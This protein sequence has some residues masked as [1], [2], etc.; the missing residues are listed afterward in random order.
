MLAPNTMLQG[1]YLVL[2]QVGKGG[3]GAVYQ[4]TDTR[5]DCTVALKEMLLTDSA[6][7]K[8]FEREAQ[9]LAR[10]RHPTLPRVSDHFL[11]GD[12]QFLVMEFIP[13]DDLAELLAR[14]GGQFPAED[15]LGWGLRWADQLLDAL[16]YLH[17]QTVPVIH[18]DIKPQNL[19]LTPRGDIILLDFGLARNISALVSTMTARHS[20]T[21]GGFTL[22]YAPLEQI[23]GS[24]PDPRSDLYALAATLYHIL[25]GVRPP[26]A[27]TRAAALLNKTDDPLRPAHTLNAQI[28]TGVAD[29]LHAALSL[30]LDERPE[31]AAAMRAALQMVDGARS[32]RRLPTLTKNQHTHTA[33]TSTITRRFHD[34]HITDPLLNAAVVAPATSRTSL[35]DLLPDHDQGQSQP[36]IAPLAPPGMLLRTIPTG[37]QLRSLAFS[38]DG[39]LLAAGGEDNTIGLWQSRTGDL[40]RTLEGHSSSIRSVTFSPDGYLLAAGGEDKTVRLWHV[41][42]GQLIYTQSMFNSHAECLAFTPDGGLLASGGWGEAIDLWRVTE[43]YLHKV[44]SLPTG[45]VHSIVFSPD[46]QILAAGCYD[47]TVRLWNVSQR[48]LVRTLEGYPNF[49]HSVAFSPDGQRLAAGGGSPTILVWRVQDGRLLDTLEGH[50]NF[51][52]S[53][54]FNH[55][56]QILA[57]GSEDK[58]V[59]LWRVRDGSLLHVLYEHTSGVMTVVFGPDGQMLA[60][61]S[62]DTKLRLWQVA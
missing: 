6:M 20:T 5:L 51:V 22:N 36:E 16:D 50:T 43:G 53:V 14:N 2:R 12:G 8:A 13:G 24:D 41:E 25:T 37:S 62:R 31:S 3:M 45:F 18:Q 35:L 59:R 9:L 11:E 7:R 29:V 54:A 32:R 58:T 4:A 60:S 39:Q 56:G 10:L 21:M 49:V 52:H 33:V 1:R 27:L 28:P 47:G 46:G 44:A 23:R 48:R 40:L 42:R 26:D 19:K 15:V 34:T 61:G 17:T 55:D 38:P 30:N 57:S